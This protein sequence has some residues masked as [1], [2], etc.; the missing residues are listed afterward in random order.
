MISPTYL[1]KQTMCCTSVPYTIV[2]EIDSSLEHTSTVSTPLPALGQGLTINTC[3]H[4]LEI[5]MG[6]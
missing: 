6:R 1:K 5:V 4:L 3:W 2:F